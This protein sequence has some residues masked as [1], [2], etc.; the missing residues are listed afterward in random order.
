MK[1][2]SPEVDIADEAISA[3]N[4]AETGPSAIQTTALL[5]LLSGCTG[6]QRHSER[7]VGSQK[8]LGRFIF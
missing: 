5:I 3:A 1:L 4:L 6:W 8:G 2:I 7:M